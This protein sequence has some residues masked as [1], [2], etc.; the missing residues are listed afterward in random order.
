MKCFCLAEIVPR[1]VFAVSLL[2]VKASVLFKPNNSFFFFKAKANQYLQDSQYIYTTLISF[3]FL[4]GSILMEKYSISFI[5][6][7]GSCV[8]RVIKTYFVWCLKWGDDLPQLTGAIKI[9]HAWCNILL[10]FICMSKVNCASI[11]GMT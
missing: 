6:P 7:T 3:P 1:D 8:V 4:Y 10:L 5:A 11:K 2:F 9:L